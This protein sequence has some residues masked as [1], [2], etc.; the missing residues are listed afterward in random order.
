MLYS[1]T[2][3]TEAYKMVKE[4]GCSIRRAS[5]LYGVPRTTLRDRLSSRVSVDCTRTGP[6]TVF[7]L[8]E[9]MK[10]C[11]HLKQL[12]VVG[13]GYTRSEV[14]NLA[15]DYAVCLEKRTMEKPLTLH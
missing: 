9:E 12:A 13:Y 3:L 6:E 5:I 4:E 15:S 11:E 14:V 8:E 7:T 2:K 1:P 10:L